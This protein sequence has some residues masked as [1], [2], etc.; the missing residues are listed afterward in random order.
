MLKRESS[1][2][3]FSFLPFFSFNNLFNFFVLASV[4]VNQNASTE[5]DVMSKTEIGWVLKYATDE[6]GA[7]DRE[8]IYDKDK[9]DSIV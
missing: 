8:K 2:I 3:V 7:W 9:L 1:A 6:I 4:V 5:A